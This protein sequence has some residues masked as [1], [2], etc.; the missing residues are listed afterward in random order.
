MNAS[1]PTHLVVGGGGGL[2]AHVVTA[3]GALGGAVVIADVDPDAAER[4]AE[5]ARGQGIDASAAVVDVRDDSSVA[6]LVAHADAVGAGLGSVVNAV[7]VTGRHRIEDLTDELLTTLLDVNVGGVVR[8][9]R[10]AVAVLRRRRHGGVVVNIASAAGLRPSP[11][12]SGYSAT[13]GAVV[14]FSRSLAAELATEGIRVWAVC[15]P[16]IETGMYLRM[17]DELDDVDDGDDRD[18]D[19]RRIV[20]AAGA[21]VGRVIRPDEVADLVAYLVSGRGPPYGAEPYVV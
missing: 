9:A 6:A 18:D 2:G 7:G 12:S 21:P 4:V 16:A 3:V 10:S 17:L 11:G 19:A 13:K 5:T 15:P 14:A 20:A 1:S 8:V